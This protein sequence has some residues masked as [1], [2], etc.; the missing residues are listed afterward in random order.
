VPVASLRDRLAGMSLFECAENQGLLSLGELELLHMEPGDKIVQEGDQR[1]FYAILEGK[2]KL[3]TPTA[4]VAPLIFKTG[5]SFGEIPILANKRLRYIGTAFE[6]SELVRFSEDKFWQLMF[7]CPSVREQV[8]GNMA[9]RLEAYQ[10]HE[11]RREKLSALGTLAAGLMHELKN[12]GTAAI[13][14][15]SQMRENLVRLQHLTLKLSRAPHSNEQ[16]D[17]LTGLQE[18]ALA[19]TCCRV[20][21]SLEQSDAEQA[22]EERLEAAGVA[23]SWRVASTLVGMGMTP[24]E[25][26]CANAAFTGEE[27][28]DSLNWLESLVS[29]VQLVGTIEE[30]LGRVRDL[31][32]AVKQYSYDDE[33]SERVVDIHESIQSTLLILGHKMRQKGLIDERD[34][35]HDL[36]KVHLR[37]GGLHQVWTNLLDNAIDASPEQGTVRMKTWHDNTSVYVSIEDHGSG[38]APANAPHV[39]EPFFTTKPVGEGTGLGLDIVQRILGMKLG[40]TVSFESVPG[41]TVFTVSL[42]AA[43]TEGAA[44]PA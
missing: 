21:S 7:A 28:S 17:C 2:I 4:M 20:M 25:L 6:P 23:N 32:M 42:P 38:I 40:G 5:E 24:Q 30:S 44:L 39:F 11:V 19:A 16:T 31:I 29:S 22:M 26:E 14:A 34:F 10:V 41:K 3:Q 9:R 33:S 12:P 27:L 13:R 15:A 36:P 18:R 1:S 8:L 35:A 37:G 43:S